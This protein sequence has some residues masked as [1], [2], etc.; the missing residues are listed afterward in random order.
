MHALNQIRN[1]YLKVEEPAMLDMP[2]NNFQLS[3]LLIL[4]DILRHPQTKT[5]SWHDALEVKPAIESNKEL[6]LSKKLS[7]FAESNL[8]G[9]ATEMGME[10]C[11]RRLAENYPLGLCVLYRVPGTAVTH[12]SV[13]CQ[14]PSHE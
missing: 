11:S 1:E 12:A 7:R 5:F 2:C 6:L 8:I 10:I 13:S 3:Y 9:I 4:L 14:K